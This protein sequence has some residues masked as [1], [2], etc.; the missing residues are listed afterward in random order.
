MWASVGFG[1]FPKISTPVENTVEKPVFRACLRKK[2]RFFG[3]FQEA[4][5]HGR[6]ILRDP[7]LLSAL[8]GPFLAGAA[9]RNPDFAAF[10]EA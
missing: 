3:I 2:P 7:A 1:F 10:F 6:A 9:G 5:V 8:Y 4:K